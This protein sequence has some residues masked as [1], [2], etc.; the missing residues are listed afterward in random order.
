AGR[1]TRCPRS[2]RPTPAALAPHPVDPAGR[3]GPPPGTPSTGRRGLVAAHHPLTSR[4]SLAPPGAGPDR[5]THPSS[6]GPQCPD[7]GPHRG[8]APPPRPPAEPHHHG[9]GG[10]AGRIRLGAHLAASHRP[11]PVE[12]HRHGGGGRAER[13]PPRS[14]PHRLPGWAERYVGIVGP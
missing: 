12:P 10:G 13:H 9:R 4:V 8:G 3:P 5:R 14:T 2:A 7:H 11:D 1:G 6:V